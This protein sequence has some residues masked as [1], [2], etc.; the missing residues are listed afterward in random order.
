M[1]ATHLEQVAEA[2]QRAFTTSTWGLTTQLRQAVTS[3]AN[4]G[5]SLITIA[6]AAKI[7]ALAVLDALEETTTTSPIVP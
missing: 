2:S 4:D 7:P 6:A 5:V 1:S 3:A